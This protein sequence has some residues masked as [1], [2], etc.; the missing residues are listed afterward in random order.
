MTADNVWFTLDGFRLTLELTVDFDL[1]IDKDLTSD[2]DSLFYNGRQNR[3]VH[4]NV[5]IQCR[6]SVLHLSFSFLIL[7]GHVG[8]DAATKARH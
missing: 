8:Q 6:G 3:P 5:F 4:N 2:T 1:F 7:F